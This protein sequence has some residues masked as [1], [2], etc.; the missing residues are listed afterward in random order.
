MNAAGVNQN[1]GANNANT[2]QDRVTGAT[3]NNTA[4]FQP[5]SIP[6]STHWNTGAHQEVLSTNM[7]V[8]PIGGSK[9][10]EIIKSGDRK[11][12]GVNTFSSEID[13]AD[14]TEFK[15]EVVNEVMSTV[16]PTS[17]EISP[18]NKLEELYKPS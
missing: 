7:L 4:G 13:P 16:N 10:Q 18:Q 9:P 3:I 2:R 17:E 12:G 14:K 15:N 5:T 11:D 6:G 1:W 8:N